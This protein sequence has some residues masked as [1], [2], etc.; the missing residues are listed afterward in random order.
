MRLYVANP[1]AQKQAVYYR[2]N[3]GREGALRDQSGAPPMVQ[4]IGPGRQ[5][6]IGGELDHGSQMD[7]IIRQLGRYGAVAWNELD[8][9]KNKTVTYVYSAEKPVPAKLIEK[10][11]Y[12]NKG[13]LTGDGEARRKAAAIAVSSFIEAPE[14]KISFEADGT[15]TGE[16]PGTNLAEGYIIDKINDPKGSKVS[17]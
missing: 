13:V 5:E 10:A 6:A 3:Y 14:A 2:M 15:M 1:T 8:R 7:D 11:F 16:E 9:V 4:H 17:A 12:H